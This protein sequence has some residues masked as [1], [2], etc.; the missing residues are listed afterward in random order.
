[1]KKNV[2]TVLGF[3]SSI[4]YVDKAGTEY[5]YTFGKQRSWN[6]P[7]KKEVYVMLAKNTTEIIL[8]KWKP[9]KIQLPKGADKQKKLVSTWSNWRVENA[10]SIWVSKTRLSKAGKI[11]RIEYTSDKFETSGDKRGKFHLYRHDFKMVVPFYMSSK[12]DSFK[13]KHPR[14]LNSRGIIA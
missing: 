10:W 2:Y 4:R 13:F 8:V 3:V 5:E 1:M 14:L 7:S 6:K 11:T 12:E 9:K